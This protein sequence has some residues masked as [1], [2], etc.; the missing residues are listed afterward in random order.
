MKSLGK[1][2]TGLRL[3]RMQASP[4]WAGEGFRNVH[5]VAPGLRDTSAPR[6]TLSDFLCG[7][8]RRVP[9]GP[10]PS[11]DP[12]AAWLQPPDSGLRATWLGHSSVL[13]EIDGHRVLTD[14]VWGP[15]ASPSR[16]AGPKRFQPAPVR[17]SHLPRPDVIVISHDHY[18]H[19]DMP[20][21]RALARHTDVPFVTSLGVGAHL[22]AF[23]VPPERIT[24]LDWWETHH[25]P[26]TGLEITAA[27]SQHFSGRSL[28]DR[29]ATL[30]SSMVVRGPR[31][32]VFFSGDTGLT[33]EYDAI[34]RRLGPFDLVMLEVGA[35]HP[36]WG[37]IH[38]GP[39]HALQAHAL[40][41]GGPLLPVHWGTFSLALHAWDEPA[42]TLLALAQPL[43]VSLLMPTLGQ[44]VEPSQ[45]RPVDPWWRAVD[46]G[47]GAPA[48]AEEPLP[49]TL[50]WPAD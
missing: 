8:E 10:L 43:G 29:N 32:A 3:E 44:A 12:R 38:L 25:V 19:L 30:W 40:L 11:T 49:G 7:G 15:R 47:R 13:I 14:P 34:R 21:V 26:G 24:E 33:T 28:G 23:D 46:G 5:P 22:E 39:A 20:T 35:F 50:P 27:P 17:L 16:L 9:R 31:H 4:R 48:R 45:Q 1:R 42:E 18:D 37:D 41:G 36:S 6:P 2:A